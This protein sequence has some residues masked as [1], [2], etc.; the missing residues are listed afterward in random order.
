MKDSS[1]I[2]NTT[3]SALAQ[4]AGAV[5]SKGFAALMTTLGIPQATILTPLVRGATIGVMNTCYDD[6]TSRALSKLENDKVNQVSETALQTF[7]ELA[8]E[9]GVTPISMQIEQGQLEYAYEVSEGL[10]LT[11]IRQS[12]RKKVDVLGRYY[13]RAF[14]KGDIDWQ[15]MHQTINMVGSLTLRQIILIR[16]ISEGFKGIDNK[17][18]ISNPSACVEVNRLKDYGIWQTEGAAFGTND[19]WAIQLESIIP[20]IYSDRVCEVL[21]LDKL[22]DEDVARTIDSLKLTTEGEPQHVLTIE[23]Y[24]QHTEW[25]EFDKDGNFVIDGGTAPIEE[26]VINDIIRGK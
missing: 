7:M 14:Y 25:Q 2:N 3:R 15:D 20:T 10:M 8:E 19:S 23:D 22:S 16:L 24:K 26:Q 11:A 13:G 17:L 18:F 12:Q 9:D 6:I 1:L 5:V 4:G 21:M